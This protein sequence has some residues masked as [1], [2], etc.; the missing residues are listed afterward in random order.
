MLLNFFTL[1]KEIN[2]I[3]SKPVIVIPTHST[4]FFLIFETFSVL[5]FALLPHICSDSKYGLWFWKPQSTFTSCMLVFNQILFK[6]RGKRG[7]K[8]PTENWL[9]N[10]NDMTAVIKII[11]SVNWVEFSVCAAVVPCSVK[12]WHF[13]SNMG[14]LNREL[15]GFTTV[16][17]TEWRLC[18]SNCSDHHPF[19]SPTG[20]TESL[21]KNK[22]SHRSIQAREFTS[23]QLQEKLAVS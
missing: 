13:V 7:G 11:K 8:N 19:S 2:C 10:C 4:F 9:V 15:D 21:L 1:S 6:S 3:I 18:W 16:N 5:K 20:G 17:D 23:I 12:A 14:H 22:I